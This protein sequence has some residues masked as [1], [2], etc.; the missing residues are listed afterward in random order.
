VKG[1]PDPAGDSLLLVWPGTQL[2]YVDHQGIWYKVL[3]DKGEGYVDQD[4]AQEQ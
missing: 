1:K 2:R 4:Y 3:T